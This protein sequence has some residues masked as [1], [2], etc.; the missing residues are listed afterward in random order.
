MGLGL[1]LLGL[2]SMGFSFVVDSGFMG[3]RVYGV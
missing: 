2:G 3:F 1:G